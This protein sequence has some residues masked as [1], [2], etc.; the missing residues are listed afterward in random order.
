MKKHSEMMFAL[1]ELIANSKHGLKPTWP[2]HKYVALLSAAINEAHK[3][4]FVAGY[5][6]GG[7]LASING[8]PMHLL[9]EEFEKWSKS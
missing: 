2:Q 5:E 1:L 7:W 4:A 8:A 3:E 9:D 6:V